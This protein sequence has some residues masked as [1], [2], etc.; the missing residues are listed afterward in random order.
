MLVGC[1][2]HLSRLATPALRPSHLGVGG[3]TGHRRRSRGSTPRVVS[4]SGCV[5]VARGS[6]DGYLAHA[7]DRSHCARR[8]RGNP[9]VRC[10]GRLAAK[11]ATDR[12]GEPGRRVE[13]QVQILPSTLP[14]PAAAVG[15]RVER[16][17]G[18]RVAQLA[19]RPPTQVGVKDAGSSPVTC[20]AQGNRFPPGDLL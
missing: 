14:A 15:G 19:G 10:A 4:A 18:V 6:A 16:T 5:T 3:M 11:D 8:P 1:V 20:A 13:A 17:A 9:T 12:P 7:A 2:H